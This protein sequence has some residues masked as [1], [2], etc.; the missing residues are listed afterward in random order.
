[1][2][3]CL[4]YLT[5]SVLSLSVMSICQFQV[6]FFIPVYAVVY[7]SDVYVAVGCFL[8]NYSVLVPGSRG[9]HT[10]LWSTPCSLSNVF[11]QVH[12][13]STYLNLFSQ[14]CSCHFI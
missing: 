10:T 6:C 5:Y 11:S 1:M 7:V 3:H 8:S 13:R 14:F 12:T 4:I 2:S 9:E